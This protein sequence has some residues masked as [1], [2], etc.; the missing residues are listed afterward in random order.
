[1]EFWAPVPRETTEAAS[2]PCNDTTGCHFLGLHPMAEVCG[3]RAGDGIH[4]LMSA[5]FTF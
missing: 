5:E 2:V 3:G 4:F 1:M